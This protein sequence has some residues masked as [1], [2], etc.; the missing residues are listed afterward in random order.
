MS[1]SEI[2]LGEVS[3]AN[4]GEAEFKNTGENKILK[5]GSRGFAKG[6]GLM[7]ELSQKDGQVPGDLEGASLRVRDRSKLFV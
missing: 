6:V 2:A 4:P 5:S 1:F 3:D 7:S